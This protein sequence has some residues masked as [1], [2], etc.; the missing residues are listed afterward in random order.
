MSTPCVGADVV[1]RAVCDPDRIQPG[2]HDALGQAGTI[3]DGPE[4]VTDDDIG[5]TLPIGGR[6]TV[7]AYA[8]T[9][10]RVE[11]NDGRHAWAEERLLDIVPE[12][13]SA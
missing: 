6:D 4:V 12:A 5:S 11:L 9:Y 7:I 10:W 1:I 3:I 8:A 2:A 13:V